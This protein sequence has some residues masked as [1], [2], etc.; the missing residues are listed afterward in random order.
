V[1]FLNDYQCRKCTLIHTLEEMQNEL[2]AIEG[3]DE[4]RATALSIDIGRLKDALRSN[5]EATLVSYYNSI[6][7]FTNKYP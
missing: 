3:K 1:D 4:E 7:Q 5:V 6:I 2:L